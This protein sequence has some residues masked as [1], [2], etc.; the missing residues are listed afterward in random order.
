MQT[1][2]DRLDRQFER[3]ENVAMIQAVRSG[4]VM[5]IP[6]L[7]IGSF[8]LVLRNL[9][10]EAYQTFL[11]AFLNGFLAEIFDFIYNGTYGMLSLIMTLTISVSY[12]RLRSDAPEYVYGPSVTALACFAVSSGLLTDGFTIEAFGVK[13]LFTAILSGVVGPWIY[14]LMAKRGVSYRFY[15]DGADVTFN[16]AISAIV[17]T[18]TAVLLFVVVNVL[19]DRLFAVSCLQE[20]FT[21]LVSAVFNGAGRSLLSAL[22]FVFVSSLLWFFGIHGGDVLE[23]VSKTIFEGGM[24][25]NIQAVAAGQPATEI[26]TK[27]FLDVFVLMGGCGA[28]L[29]ILIAILLFSRQRTTRSLSKM[30]AVPM[31]FNINELMVFGLPIVFN[32]ILLIPFLLTP[33]VLTLI[34]AGAI[35]LGLVPMPVQTVDWTTPILIGGYLA[36]GSVAGVLLQLFNLAVGVC[37]Y[38]PFVRVLDR[39]KTR[40]S[41]THMQELKAV[42]AESEQSNTPVTLTALHGACGMIAKM[43]AADLK[44]AVAHEELELYYQPQCDAAHH[45]VGAEALLRWN[46]PLFG[47]VYPPLIIK[48]ADESGSLPALERWIFRTAAD[49]LPRLQEAAGGPFRLSVNA[50]AKAI[51]QAGLFGFVDELLRTRRIA[52]GAFCLEVTEQMALQLHGA[53]SDNI[54]RLLARGV[55][56][57]IDDF[58]MG[59]TSLRY[60]Q[61]NS[62]SSVKLDGSLVRDLLHNPRCRDIISSIVYLSKSLGFYV[63]AEYV[64]TAEQQAEL[65]KLGCELYQ[66]YLYSPAIPLEDYL[67]ILRGERT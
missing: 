24:D 49:A 26:F 67:T 36:T 21:R 57:A 61:E 9:P 12:T 43:L 4:L 54:R 22:L 19:L 18:L 48:I 42:L 56:I 63:V 29:C 60:L 44:H 51:A 8:A 35:G 1:P 47:M 37:I 45:W 6:I 10:I 32:P 41:Q 30:A 38:V 25:V 7:L 33:V 2:L 31:L 17:P 46:H 55:P 58:S 53:A 62:F 39:E 11:H 20:L 40:R 23:Q 28:S 64:E 34:S 65:A 50:S 14:R 59:S 27:T 52:A 13:G 66:G 3:V 5:A 15:T 16:N